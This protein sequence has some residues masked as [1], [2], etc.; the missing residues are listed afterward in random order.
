MTGGG[1]TT[2]QDACT[3][4]AGA[5]TTADRRCGPVL[6]ETDVREAHWASITRVLT[7][8]D[9]WYQSRHTGRLSLVVVSLGQHS[10]VT[11]AG[12]EWL[13]AALTNH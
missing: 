8:V 10:S 7:V 12:C 5:F 3:G 4:S 6:Q 9:W 13:R 1:E 11:Q 2:S